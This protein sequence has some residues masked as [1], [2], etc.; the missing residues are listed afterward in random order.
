MCYVGKQLL[1]TQDIEA[2]LIK[3]KRPMWMTFTFK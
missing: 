2:I 3:R 1:C